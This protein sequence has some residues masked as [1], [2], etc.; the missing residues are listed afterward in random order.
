[1][2]ERKQELLKKMLMVRQIKYVDLHRED[3][4]ISGQTLV[5]VESENI[6]QQN[7]FLFQEF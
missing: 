6:L 2:S 5:K 7:H 3:K 4:P 1:M